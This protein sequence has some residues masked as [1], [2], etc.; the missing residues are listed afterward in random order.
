[1]VWPSKVSGCWSASA[2]KGGVLLLKVGILMHTV[3][4]INQAH[5]SVRQLT[6]ANKGMLRLSAHIPISGA[7]LYAHAS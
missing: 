1:M 3:S 2:H 7:H 6:I 4:A 5:P